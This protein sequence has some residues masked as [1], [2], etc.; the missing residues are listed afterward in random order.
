MSG[1]PTWPHTVS[2]RL[3]NVAA[4]GY[5]P[6]HTVIETLDPS[7]V[8]K[9][10]P[11]YP[12][13]PGTMDQTKVEEIRR[14]IYVSN[15]DPRVTFEHLHDLF[16]Q[17]GEVKYMRM[18]RSERGREYENLGLTGSQSIV[19]PDEDNDDIE[20]LSNDSVA[21]FIEFSEQPSMV[22]ALCLNGLQFAGRSIKVNLFD[23]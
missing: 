9:S 4:S 18:T 2:N 15:L 12:P 13:M 7:L 11:V 20:I 6:A 1:G 23:F 5:Q 10:L 3:V 22:K 19:V 16:S 21:A 17:V 8:L 14:T